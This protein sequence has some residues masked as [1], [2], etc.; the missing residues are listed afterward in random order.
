LVDLTLSSINKIP[1]IAAID[2]ARGIA[3]IAMAV[4]H[5][6]WDLEF[7]GLAR[8]GMTVEPQWKYFARTIASSFL[9]LVGIGAWLA[10][11]NKFA[12]RTF[13]RRVVI[14]GAAALFITIATYYGSP[15]NYIFFGILHNITLSSVLILLFLR[16]PLPVII[17]CAIATLSAPWWAKTPLLDDPIWWWTGLSSVTPVALD[18]VPVFPWFGWVLVGLTLGRL[19]TK[20]QAWDKLSR[21]QFTDPSGRLMRFF[22]RNSLLFYLLHQPTLMALVYLYVKISAGI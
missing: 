18:Y 9:V 13:V 10:H 14:V 20:W 5:F 4:F 12:V 8:P 7:F 17:I 15:Q 22:G 11:H 3:L 1:R 16:L 21:L 6:G 19:F 2:Y